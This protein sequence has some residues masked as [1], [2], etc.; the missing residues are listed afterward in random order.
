MFL[1]LIFVFCFNHINSEWVSVAI[2]TSLVNY[3]AVVWSSSSNVVVV[4]DSGGVLRSTDQGL[5]F[6]QYTIPN[7][8]SIQDISS[9]SF[10]FQ[11]YLLAVEQNGNVG[12][13]YQSTDGVSWVLK[14][15]TPEKLY[16]VSIGNN[17]NAYAAGQLYSV[18]RSTISNYSVWNRIAPS[19]AVQNKLFNAISTYDGVRVITAGDN[20]YV[21]YSKNNGSNWDL[22]N[23]SRTTLGMYGLSHGNASTAMM[24]GASSYV[25]ITYNGGATWK[26]LSVF[27]D[28]SYSCKFHTISM[29]NPY[30]AFI[31]GSTSTKS[32]IYS[33]SN[34]GAAWTLEKTTSN[35]IY[36]LSVHSA[37]TGIAVSAK[38]SGFYTKVAGIYFYC[39]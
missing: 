33:T 3:Q 18:Y 7:A 36:G 35:I 21:Y 4:G 24:A 15:Q 19:I 27:S 9:I 17:G 34:A 26:K 30:I 37:I 22:G 8:K 5:T 14:K 1:F 23:T 32:F 12:K 29:L 16:A 6:S 2:P 20:G 11:T 10:N 25:A 28:N 39:S 31:S 13:V 38:G